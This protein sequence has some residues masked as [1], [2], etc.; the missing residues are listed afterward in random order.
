M[1]TDQR[2]LSTDVLT[3]PL[4]ADELSPFDVV[5]GPPRVASADL[6]EASGVSIGVWEITPGVVTDTEVDEVFLVVAG[7]GQ[8]AFEDGATVML[9]P[10]ALIRL[11]AGE[12]TT[13]TITET[14]RKVYVI[15]PAMMTPG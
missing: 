1:N 7:S 12:R 10:G 2:A 13:W 15:L 4:T 11:R 9:Q 6:E 8:I 14:V 3:E 5:D